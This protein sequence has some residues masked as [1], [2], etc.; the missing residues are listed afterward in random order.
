[1]VRTEGAC[2]GGVARGVGVF[3]RDVP[4][5]RGVCRGAV[6]GGRGLDKGGVAKG[7]GRAGNGGKAKEASVSGLLCRTG[8]TDGQTEVKKVAVAKEEED[9]SGKDVLRCVGGACKGG[10]AG[11]EGRVCR[12]SGA[13]EEGGASSGGVAK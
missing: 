6:A 3:L 4:R 2:R 7:E 12:E 13:E 1:M 8:E 9:A 10:V 5:D 11:R